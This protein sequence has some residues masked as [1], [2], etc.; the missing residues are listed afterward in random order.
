MIIPCV[1]FEE[2]KESE[3]FA[4]RDG[5]DIRYFMKMEPWPGCERNAVDLR[6]A[7]TEFFN[8]KDDVVKV[9]VEMYFDVEED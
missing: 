3:C 7:D 2:L 1:K 5:E 4:V 8:A 9:D 6:S